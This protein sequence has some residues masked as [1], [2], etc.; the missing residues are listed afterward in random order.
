MVWTIGSIQL[1]DFIKDEAVCIGDK[2]LSKDDDS[3]A[4][5]Y[6]AIVSIYGHINMISCFKGP[7][8]SPFL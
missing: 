8:G 3:F 1:E 6:V 4:Q 2:F 5:A 7:I